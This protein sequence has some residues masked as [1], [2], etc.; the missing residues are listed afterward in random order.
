MEEENTEKNIEALEEE[1]TEY[2]EEHPEEDVEV[3]EIEFSL[4]E[5]EIEDWINELRL[6]KEE[7][8]PI[9]LNVDDETDLK[10]SFEDEESSESEENKK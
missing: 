9:T 3:E 1:K 6:L 5:D 2:L 8:T 7:K 10:I 4:D